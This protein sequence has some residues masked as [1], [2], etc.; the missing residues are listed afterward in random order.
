MM[1]A[2]TR[3]EWFHIEFQLLSDFPNDVIK[4]LIV[5]RDLADVTHPT[6]SFDFRLHPLSL[7]RGLLA[8]SGRDVVKILYVFRSPSDP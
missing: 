4:V 6:R 3:H 2:N 1:Y 7:S 8:L 5:R